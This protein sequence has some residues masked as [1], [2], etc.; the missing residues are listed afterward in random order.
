MRV[1]YQVGSVAGKCYFRLT[2]FGEFLDSLKLKIR[3]RS[4]TLRKDATW[5]LKSLSNM[6]TSSIYA[7]QLDSRPAK[8]QAMILHCYSYGGAQGKIR[9]YN[10]HNLCRAPFHCILSPVSS[11]A[12]ERFCRRRSESEHDVD[13]C[14]RLGNL[15]SGADPV[16]TPLAEHK[17]LAELD[18][19]DQHRRAHQILDAVY[20]HR[21]HLSWSI[22][23]LPPPPP[24]ASIT[25]GPWQ[26]SLRGDQIRAIQMGTSD[27][28]LLVIQTLFVAGKSVWC[29]H[30]CQAG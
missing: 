24:S 30:C 8:A 15:P 21:V 7:T 1:T 4:K 18:K 16:F 27:I 20:D 9:A 12:V 5:L 14:V 6:T 29:R 23:G 28:P 25:L 13:I 2:D 19:D 10:P 17:I 3:N 11:R 22:P 26:L